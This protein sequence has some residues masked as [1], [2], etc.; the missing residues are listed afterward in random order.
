VVR[1]CAITAECV[2]LYVIFCPQKAVPE[3]A[4]AELSAAKLCACLRRAG[5]NWPGLAAPGSLAN[6]TLQVQLLENDL[7]ADSGRFTD[8][9]HGPVPSWDSS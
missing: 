1:Y 2:L 4:T 7:Q 3:V 9:V 8:R 5:S 6:I